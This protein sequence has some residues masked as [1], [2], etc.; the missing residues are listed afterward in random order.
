M[1]R[2]LRKVD[3]KDLITKDEVAGL[4]REHGFMGVEF[5]EEGVQLLYDQSEDGEMMMA[6]AWKIVEKYRE[7]A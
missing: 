6:L 1:A 2:S 5:P 4:M 3:V 7:A